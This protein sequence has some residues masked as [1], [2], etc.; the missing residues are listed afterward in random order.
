M[1]CEQFL[2]LRGA[3][4]EIAADSHVLRRLVLQRTRWG[5]PTATVTFTLLEEGT[6]EQSR[7]QLEGHLD[8]GAPVFSF[9]NKPGQR[10]LLMN[11]V[12]G[13]DAERNEAC[14]GPWAAAGA[15]GPRGRHSQESP[16]LGFFKR[17]GDSV[18]MWFKGDAGANVSSAA[19]KTP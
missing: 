13:P 11:G 3:E 18:W 14:E 15:A 12:F 16:M 19:P 10:R 5:R 1:A 8:A 6:Q 4:L 7:Y 9:A 17:F 2:A